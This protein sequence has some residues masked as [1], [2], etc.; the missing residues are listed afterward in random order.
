MAFYID[1]QLYFDFYVN[2]YSVPVTLT[3]INS[4]II[5]SNCYDILPALRLD[6]ND[7]KGIFSQGLLVDGTTISIAVGTDQNNASENM[8]EFIYSTSPEE[9]K[10]KAKDRYLI[11]ATYN[12]PKL[13]CMEPIGIYG[14]SSQ[15][16]TNIASKVG[17]AADVKYTSDEMV[18]LNGTRNYGEFI[19]YITS[20]GYIDDTSCMM[21]CIDLNRKLL[22]KDINSLKYDYT[23]TEAPV[24]D[25]I[26]SKKVQFNEIE[27]ANNSAINNYTYGY[28]NILTDYS[29][30]GDINSFNK[31][32]FNKD[33]TALN[34]NS[35]IFNDTGNIRNSFMATNLGNVHKNWARAYY[36]N[37]RYR[38]L[39]SIQAKVYCYK[40][41][42]LNVLDGVNLSL[43]DPITTQVDTVKSSK[44]LITSKSIGISNKQY[45]EK[46]GI[47]TTGLNMDLFNNLM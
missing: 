29:L 8:M 24:E 17:L 38:S 15:A 3:D 11:Y 21:S 4:M 13:R 30:S 6:I 28:Q 32:S 19:K 31:I 26:S 22:Y 44:W 1:N 36:Q 20:Y 2:G 46:Y 14:T 45:I 27:F 33:S 43:I 10:S 40:K 25:M 42:P 39:Y 16:L 35:K 41:T 12:Y 9:V 18:W 47:A 7:N 5:T 23:F 34:I 37:L